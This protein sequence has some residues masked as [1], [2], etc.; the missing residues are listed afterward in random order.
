MLK[1]QRGS[2]LKKNSDLPIK[3]VRCFTREQKTSQN[4]RAQH[5]S[6][7]PYSVPVYERYIKSQKS[8]TKKDVWRIK[9]SHQIF[10]R[11]YRTF[12]LVLQRAKSVQNELLKLNCTYEYEQCLHCRVLI[13]THLL[14]ATLLG[15]LQSLMMII[16]TAV[17]TA[18]S[19]GTHSTRESKTASHPLSTSATSCSL[20]MYTGGSRVGM[21][22]RLLTLIEKKHN[23]V[24]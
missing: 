10:Y 15:R 5:A 23:L 14:M 7:S 22:C 9:T 13:L 3:T 19:M 2:I 11:N 4:E 20:S 16:M 12:R 8:C 18:S 17:P 1:Y 24:I 21:S 6:S